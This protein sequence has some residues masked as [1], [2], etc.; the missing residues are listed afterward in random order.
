MSY[1]KNEFRK[2][3]MT[4]HEH[5]KILCVDDH[6]RPG[7]VQSIGINIGFRGSPGPPVKDVEH[8][9]ILKAVIYV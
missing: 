3:S 6:Y 2:T 8:G 1:Q 9:A 7:K 5:L 4:F